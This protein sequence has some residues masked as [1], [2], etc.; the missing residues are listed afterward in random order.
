MKKR[1][2]CQWCNS[3]RCPFNHDG[4]CAHKYQ[5]GGLCMP[6]DSDKEYKRLMDIIWKN[7]Q[8]FNTP[9]MPK[10]SHEAYQEILNKFGPAVEIKNDNQGDYYEEE[11]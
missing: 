7:G 8:S 10:E 4:P 5:G 9:D 3:W 11:I 6:Y 2:S 1:Y